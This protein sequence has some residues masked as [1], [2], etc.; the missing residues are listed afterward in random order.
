MHKN[1]YNKLPLSFQQ[2]FNKIEFV[3]SHQTRK[4]T[5]FKYFL[6]RVSKTAGQKN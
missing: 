4:L 3:H 6:P 5:K 1:C 2:R